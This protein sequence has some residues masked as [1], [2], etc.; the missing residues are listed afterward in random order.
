MCDLKMLNVVLSIN[1]LNKKIF[2]KKP[3]FHMVKYDHFSVNI[4]LFNRFLTCVFLRSIAK[5]IILMME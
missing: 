3:Y 1:T 5:L 4:K 2:L